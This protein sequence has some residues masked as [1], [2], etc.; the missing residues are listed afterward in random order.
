LRIIGG[1]LRGRKLHKFR[2]AL[3]RPTSDKLRESI[4]NI[5]GNRVRTKKVLDLFAGT[6]AL[7]LEALSRGAETALFVEM[8][9]A[10]LAL[11]RRNI[12]SCQMENRSKTIRWD[13]TRN[14]NC[15]KPM[16]L[17]FDIVFLDPPYAGDRIRPAIKNL[18]DS[19]ALADGARMII[20]HAASELIAE[21]LPQIRISDRRRYGKSIVSILEYV[22]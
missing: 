1:K 12:S 13:I 6:G 18:I 17:R 11:I 5:L 21:N 20:E 7:G 15:L 2:G 16:G 8:R 22:V 10:A 9:P 14:L 3:I 19:R 4:F